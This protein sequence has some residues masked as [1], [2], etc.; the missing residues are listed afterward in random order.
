MTKDFYI[1]ASPMS[2]TL[3]EIAAST[4]MLNAE[5]AES[6]VGMVC[7]TCLSFASE[8]DELLSLSSELFGPV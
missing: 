3:V 8:P 2:E 4:R 5:F 1:V 7:D 6:I